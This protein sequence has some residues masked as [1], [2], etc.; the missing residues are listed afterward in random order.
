MLFHWRM[1]IG[2]KEEAGSRNAV[3]VLAFNCFG[4]SLTEDGQVHSD[5][6]ICPKMRLDLG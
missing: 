1:L 2:K 6:L 3:G 5:G 4:R